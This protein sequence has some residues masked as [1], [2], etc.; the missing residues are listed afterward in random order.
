M[1]RIGRPRTPP[2][3]LI[4]RTARAMPRLW[5]WPKVASGPVS[6]LTSPKR[7]SAAS[8]CPPPLVARPPDRADD[9]FSQAPRASAIAKRS[10]QARLDAKCR[11][12]PTP[13]GAWGLRRLDIHLP[14]VRSPLHSPTDA[15]ADRDGR[16]T[17]SAAS[18]RP[19]L[20]Q[21]PRKGQ[22]E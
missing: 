20:H 22:I 2:A 8:A 12:C 15:A 5:D 10:R 16:R 3:S 9:F 17:A 21:A 6:E 18:L 1:T 11:C 13:V 4:S 7:I 14:A 19:A